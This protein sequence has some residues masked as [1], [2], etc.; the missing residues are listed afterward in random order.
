MRNTSRNPI[1]L[2]DLRLYSIPNLFIA[3][4]EAPTWDPD[5]SKSFSKYVTELSKWKAH[6]QFH[7]SEK[8]QNYAMINVRSLLSILLVPYTLDEVNLVILGVSRRLDEHVFFKVLHAFFLEK[9]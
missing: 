6:T 2:I 1:M 9:D 4:A 7:L 5:E 3:L 8:G